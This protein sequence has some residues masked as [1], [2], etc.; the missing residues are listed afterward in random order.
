[1]ADI[2]WAAPEE[3][4]LTISP[5]EDYAW[6]DDFGEIMGLVPCDN[7]GEMVSKVYL[8]VV[9]EKHMCIPCSGYER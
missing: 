6:C 5:V 7:C 3:E 2:V 4:V 9:G 8:R 1:M